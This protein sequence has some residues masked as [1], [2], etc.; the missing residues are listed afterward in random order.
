MHRS[1]VVFIALA[2][3]LSACGTLEISLETPPPEVAEIPVG[4][5]PQATAE[6]GLS[7]ASTSE[8]IQRAMLES[9]TKWKSIWMDGTV[10]YFAMEG[11]DSQTSTAR[12][13]VWI[14]LTTN[15][16]RVLTGPTDG[17]AEQFLASDG[18]SILR[19]DL[20]T[21]LSDS[22][23]MPELPQ[24][25]FVPT[26]QPGFGY[27]QPLWGQMGTP[28]SQLAFPSD[29][30]QSEGRFEPVA[31]EFIA[32]REALAVEW[33]YIQNE[34]PSWRMWLDTKTAVILK[35][36]SFDKSGGDTPRSEAVVDQIRFD[37]IFADSL[38]RAPASLP[39]FSD[40]TGQPLTSDQ[41]APTVSSD[42]D[43]LREVYFFVSD[44]KYGDE[45][46]QLVRVPGSCAAGLS[47]CPEPEALE[48]PFDLKFSLMSF[49][50]SPDGAV[51]AFPYPISED[52]NRAALFLFEPESQTWDSM[53]EF[54]YID[55]PYWS[56][57]GDWLAF[58]VQDGNGN[59]DIYAIR[60]D[61]SQ[62]TNLTDSE[63]LTTED[64]PYVLNGWINNSVILRG[65]RN[66]TV[67][68]LRVDDGLVKPLFETPWQKSD[69]V[70]SPDGYFLAYMDITEQ[71]T[72][73]KLLTPDDKTAR[74]LTSFQNASLYP[75]VWSPDGTS[76]AFARLTND[77]NDGQD[78]YLIDR[79]GSNLQQIHHSDAGGITALDFSPD[80]KYLLFQDNDAAGQH[81]FVVDLTTLTP[82]MLQVPSLPLDWWWLAPSWR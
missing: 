16:F 80:G 20:K 63:K 50:W 34:L 41:P 46:I 70:P 18:F 31:L 74:T 8:E 30:A 69:L 39:D 29:F 23:P 59:E 73:L 78:V 44:H 13:Q 3:L 7:L 19:M 9:A 42:P 28:L 32:G 37:D 40:V 10:T 22:Q 24:P 61:G 12:E 26:L 33:T 65:R 75:I 43:P 77:P 11:T 62:L 79:D 56:P 57:D 49:V 76:L 51:A 21:G 6:P 72:D 64:R 55:P 60:R 47:P 48:T 68:L 67:Y 2:L 52:G 36:Q 35:M 66:E 25:P 45:K 5:A 17:P 1:I 53:V 81:I 38:F 14:D 82:H 15:R 54:N 4:S 58:R 27:P 71:K